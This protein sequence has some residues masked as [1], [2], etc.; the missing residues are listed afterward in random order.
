MCRWVGQSGD[1]ESNERQMGSVVDC[2]RKAA[3]GN[4]RKVHGLG[5]VRAGDRDR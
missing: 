1:G 3:L 4:W 5:E 2:L